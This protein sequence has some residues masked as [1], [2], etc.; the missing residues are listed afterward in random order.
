M[1]RREAVQLYLLTRFFADR[2]IRLVAFAADL[3]ARAKILPVALRIRFAAAVITL[4]AA[5]VER[6]FPPRSDLP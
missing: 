4:R 6:F 1:V 3:R 5:A 2:M